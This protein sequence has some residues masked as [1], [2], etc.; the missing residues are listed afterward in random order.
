MLSLRRW[1]LLTALVCSPV[2]AKEIDFTRYLGD[3][4]FKESNIETS[5]I[6]TVGEGRLI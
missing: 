6:G 2:A 5:F 3:H 1:I 4:S